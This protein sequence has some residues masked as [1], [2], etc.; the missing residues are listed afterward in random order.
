MKRDS[1]QNAGNDYCILIISMIYHIIFITLSKLTTR[2][3]IWIATSTWCDLICPPKCPLWLGVF[4][5]TWTAPKIE[6]LWYRISRMEKNIPHATACFVLE[7]RWRFRISDAE[8]SNFEHKVHCRLVI[9]CPPF[10]NLQ[11]DENS[12]VRFGNCIRTLPCFMH[13]AQCD[14]RPYLRWAALDRKASGRLVTQTGR[15]GT[16][17]CAGLGVLHFNTVNYLI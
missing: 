2:L 8:T 13:L 14:S 7:I 11:P 6:F 12:F 15:Q 1:L 5:Y 17:N 16:Q 10:T 4:K 3:K 9:M